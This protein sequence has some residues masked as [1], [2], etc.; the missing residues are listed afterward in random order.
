[1]YIHFNGKI[2]KSTNP[3]ILP[4]SEGFLYGYGLFETI[5]LYQGK[6]FFFA[7]H[8]AR[9]EAGCKTLGLQLD[10]RPDEILNYCYELAQANKLTNGGIRITITK[11]NQETSLAITTRANIYSEEVYQKGF[12]ILFARAKRNPEAL[13]VGV[14]TNNYLENLLT[15]N[16]AKQMGYDEAVFLNVYHK[17]SEGTISNIFFVKN[18]KIFTPARECGL[19]PGIIRDKVLDIAAKLRLPLKIGQF[20]KEDLLNADEIFLTNSLLD[21]MPVARIEAKDLDIQGNHVTQKLQMELQ[22][23]YQ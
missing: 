16:Q 7:E 3:N 22:K 8:F 18:N 10:K 19:L 20:T 4:V 5:K 2:L 14:K 6:I 11:N 21:I 17:V 15:L 12:N 1:M 13:L 9:M 23:L